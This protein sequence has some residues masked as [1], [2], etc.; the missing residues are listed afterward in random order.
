MKNNNNNKYYVYGYLRL[1]NNSYFYI[2]KGK[3]RR[4]KKTGTK[5]R[6][7]EFKEIYD[8]NDCCAEII[9]DN[10][11]EEEAFNI[12]RNTIEDLVLNEGYSI[13]I[14][15]YCDKNDD[16]HLVNHGF[17]GK[18]NSGFKFSNE[19]KK[20]MSNSKKG[21]KN[22][23]YG[24]HHTEETRK[25]IGDANRGRK[26][27]EETL[28]KLS[29]AS[30]G[31]KLSEDAKRK[32]SE[33]RKGELNPMYG[34]TPHNK[35]KHLSEETKAKISKSKKGKKMKNEYVERMI[36]NSSKR[37]PIY[38]IELDMEFLG[39]RQAMNYIKETYNIPFDRN[40]L[41]KKLRNN[42]IVEYG[43]IEMNGKIIKLHW[44]YI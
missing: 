23:M 31:R 7:K 18:D 26:K 38:C 11:T 21:V 25:K 42:N 5:S 4:Y 2:G 33:S 12:E 34:K 39:V 20:K 24:K 32:L 9:K 17:G 8:N 29:L 41:T 43:K 13:D 27:S 22:N 37:T 44:K 40:N 3:D 35:G 36:I 28:R 14:P 16:S 1:D 30:K 19:T 10:L 15:D 6:S